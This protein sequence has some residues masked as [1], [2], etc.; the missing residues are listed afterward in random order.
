[1]S[2]CLASLLPD[3]AAFSPASTSGAVAGRSTA[4]PLQTSRTSSRWQTPCVLL[5]LPSHTALYSP[6]GK[7]F[8]SVQTRFSVPVENLDTQ[9]ERAY[10][11]GTYVKGRASGVGYSPEESLEELAFLAESAGLQVGI[12][13]AEQQRLHSSLENQPYPF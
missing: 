3:Q 1:M 11:V 5:R 6:A 4:E 8:L 2:A 13:S 7:R 9:P 12:L 10:L